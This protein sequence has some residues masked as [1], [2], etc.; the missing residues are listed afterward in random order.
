MYYTKKIHNLKIMKTK[1]SQV[2][3]FT[4]FMNEA[5]RI[6]GAACPKIK[7][8]RKR[9]KSSA[10]FQQPLMLCFV[11]ARHLSKRLLDI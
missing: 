8:A 6:R 10:N 9:A 3:E 11:M 2:F 4:N 1:T 7:N 5:R